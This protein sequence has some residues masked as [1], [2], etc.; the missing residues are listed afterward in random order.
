[1]DQGSRR[2]IPA[3]KVRQWIPEWDEIGWKP[4]EDRSKPPKW[5]YQFSIPARDLK[6][7]SGVYRRTTDRERAAA[8]RGIQRRHQEN[9]SKEIGRFVRFGYPWSDLS[10]AK[11]QSSEFD[12]L[13]QPGWL[14]TA[15]VVNIL[16][17]EQERRGQRVSHDDLVQIK[18]RGRVA[19]VVL[20]AGLGGRWKPKSIPPIEVIDGQHRLWAFDEAS[21]G[22]FEIPKEFEVPVVAFCGLDLSW[23]AYLFYTINIKPKR[24]NAS[25]AFDL[26]P[27]L[28][29]EEW[30][31]KVE[32]HRIY[33]ETR[34]QEI[35]D[36][37]WWYDGSPWHRRI[38]ML[39]DPKYRGLQVTQ[40]AWIRSLLAS[41]VKRG[42]GKR[43]QLGG[44]FAARVGKRQEA[45]SWS[46]RQQAAFLILIGQ[47]LRDA[48]EKCEERWAGALRNPSASRAS[49]SSPSRV[50]ADL[51]FTGKHNLLNQDQGIRVL[52]QV[53]N[54]LHF[55]S[56]DDLALHELAPDE[57]LDSSG[58]GATDNDAVRASVKQ[59]REQE[60]LLEFVRQLTKR[61]AV[62]DWRSSNAPGLESAE[63]ILK[64]GFRGSSGY[65]DLREHVLRH[66]AADNESTSISGAAE[67]VMECLGYT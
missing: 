65:R 18:N 27:L 33:R 57:D 67:Q 1:M 20:P 34:A 16:T 40:A 25:L 26:Y 19:D 10:P 30:L 38:N 11:Q 62:Y 32:G 39:G 21:S 51:A 3:L 48:I 61:L 54:D 52:L 29:T 43:P 49:A 13:R 24:I 63:Q 45:L 12:D 8:D 5:F 15:I 28:R 9:R 60:K 58:N 56:A 6:R 37:L 2:S 64:A 7:L 46:R 44:L 31:E 55:E 35:V 14:P 50:K 42:R 17:E 22:N 41:F 47:E 59:F 4:E 36:M 66:L 23:Q 53:V